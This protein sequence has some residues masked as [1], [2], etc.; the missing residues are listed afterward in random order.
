MLEKK[1]GRKKGRL[2]VA[3]NKCVL[4]ACLKQSGEFKWRVLIN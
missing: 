4:F 3:D 1:S 2:K